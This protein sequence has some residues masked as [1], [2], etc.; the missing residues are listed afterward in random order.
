M[1]LHGLH[2]PVRR[3]LKAKRHRVGNYGARI[4]HYGSWRQHDNANTILEQ[5]LKTSHQYLTHA[6]SR[7]LDCTYCHQVLCHRPTDI[8]MLQSARG[9]LKYTHFSITR[10][11]R[12][13]LLC[14]FY[15]TSD[16]PCIQTLLH[17]VTVSNSDHQF[18]RR[19]HA[20]LH[21]REMGFV[22]IRHCRGTSQGFYGSR[23]IDL[24]WLSEIVGKV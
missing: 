22:L 24:V 15:A 7:L 9:S 6:R 3:R 8:V 23:T 4:L 13:T 1:V 21:L 16:R 10:A 5:L 18:A 11:R 2:P 14:E 19:P 12:P 17:S 20:I